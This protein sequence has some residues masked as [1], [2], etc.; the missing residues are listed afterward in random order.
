[1]NTRFPKSERVHLEDKIQ[2]LLKSPA[3]S[4]YPLR[5]TWIKNDDNKA[6]LL[7]LVSKKKLS[8]AVDRNTMKRRIR[9]TFRTHKSALVGYSVAVFFMPS[10]LKSSE[11]LEK[12]FLSFSARF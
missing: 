1:L 9:E 5:F 3:V 11:D 4:Y 2:V 12:A 10:E 7:V 6:E 8:L